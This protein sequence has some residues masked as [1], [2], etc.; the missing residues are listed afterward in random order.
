MTDRPLRILYLTK[1]SDRGES[2]TIIGVHQAGH[3]VQLFADTRSAHVQRIAEAGRG[4]CE[5]LHNHTMVLQRVLTLAF[6]S[7]FDEDID[8]VIRD[9]A[10]RR[11]RVDTA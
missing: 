4:V 3:Q 10:T 5:P 6:G 8:A 2:A 9:V 7:Q 11:G 1:N